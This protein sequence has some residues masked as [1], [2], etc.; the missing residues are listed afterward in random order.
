MKATTSCKMALRGVS[1]DRLCSAFT[2]AS[3][4]LGLILAQCII[5]RR[6][7][8]SYSLIMHH[9]ALLV[10]LYTECQSC[11]R[12]C[13][14]GKS[15]YYCDMLLLQLINSCSHYSYLLHIT[16]VERHRKEMGFRLNV[17]KSRI[18]WC[19]LF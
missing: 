15:G 5:R 11:R 14:T 2:A 7:S 16:V 19:L 10:H 8:L 3:G 4:T 12:S 1:G 18:L 6:S 9:H 17:S 13:V